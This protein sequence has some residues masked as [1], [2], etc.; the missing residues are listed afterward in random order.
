M[1]VKKKIAVDIL[2]N[3]KK[4]KHVKSRTLGISKS[5]IDYFNENITNIEKILWPINNIKV[6]TEKNIN[7]EILNFENGKKQIFSI[8][9][10]F[11]LEKKLNKL[12]KLNKLINFKNISSYENII[13]QDYNLINTDRNHAITTKFF[14]IGWKKL[15]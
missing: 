3:K 5:N 1:L 11:E 4:N 7:K 9:R 2:L 14:L 8:I 13:K 12:L 6:F 10:N 15:Y